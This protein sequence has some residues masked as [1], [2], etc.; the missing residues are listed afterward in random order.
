MSHIKKRNI[1]RKKDRKLKKNKICSFMTTFLNFGLAI[2]S[3]A[4]AMVFKSIFKNLKFQRQILAK[5]KY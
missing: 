2:K 5:A 3:A 4:D 1:L